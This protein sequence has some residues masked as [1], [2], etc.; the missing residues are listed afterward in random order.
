MKLIQCIEVYFSN[1]IPVPAE[2]SEEEG[3]LFRLK[4]FHRYKTTCLED[5]GL[6]Y[7]LKSK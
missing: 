1:D 7:T 6:Y 3:V 5:N 4:L 2:L